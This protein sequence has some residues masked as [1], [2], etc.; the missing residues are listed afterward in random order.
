[1]AMDPEEKKRRARERKKQRQQER[2]EVVELFGGPA[3][4]NNPD[5]VLG[6]GQH[7]PRPEHRKTRPRDKVRLSPNMT[8]VMRRINA[9]ETTMDDVV[10]AMDPE[11]LVRGCFKGSDGK[12]KRPPTIVPAA[13]HQACVRELLQ[14]GQRLYRTHFLTAIEAFT[15]IAADPEMEPQHRLKAA[16]YIWERV[17]GKVPDRVE[18]AAAKPWETIIDGIIAEAEDDQISRAARVLGE[19]P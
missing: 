2:G 4:R 16:Q 13:F 8:E 19:Q 9:G 1:M 15:Q 12:F 14:R 7:G 6:H 11:E 3:P 10:A 18:V 5:D 17:E